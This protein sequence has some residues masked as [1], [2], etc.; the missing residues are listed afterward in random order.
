MEDSAARRVLN[1]NQA[2]RQLSSPGPGA[3]APRAL[4]TRLMCSRKDGSSRTACSMHCV[5]EKLECHA[6]AELLRQMS[7][8]WT[9]MSQPLQLTSFSSQKLAYS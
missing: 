2:V 8:P 3:L 9:V 1:N 5:H 4:N 7:Q 6:L